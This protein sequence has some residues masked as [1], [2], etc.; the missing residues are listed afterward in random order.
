MW[1]PQGAVLIR[2]GHLFEAGAQRKHGIQKKLKNIGNKSI[3]ANIY[4]IQVYDSIM[5]GYFCL[6]FI[7]FLIKGKSLLNYTSL[8][9]PNEYEKNKK[10]IMKY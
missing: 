9:S 2:G 6:G 10:I 4:R 7:D 5:C 8:F 1:M 3:I